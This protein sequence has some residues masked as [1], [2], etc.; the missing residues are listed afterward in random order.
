MIIRQ[1]SP[2]DWQA[3]Q[4][5]LEELGYPAGDQNSVT[6]GILKYTQDGYHL[7]VS[8]VNGQPIGFISLHWYNIFHSPKPVGRI[9]AM[10]VEPQARGQEVGSGLLAAGEG[11]LRSKGCDVVE[12]TSHV[13]RTL[14]HRF[15]LKHGYSEDSKRFVKRFTSGKET[16]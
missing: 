6:S 13:R 1:A 15:Y 5:L 2:H 4:Q 12:V 7:I 9:T 3:I 16:P 8:E 11:Y 10:C 14:T